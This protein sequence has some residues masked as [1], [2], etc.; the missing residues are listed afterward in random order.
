MHVEKYTLLLWSL[1]VCRQLDQDYDEL[2]ETSGESFQPHAHDEQ[3]ALLRLCLPVPGD[4]F[5]G[6]PVHRLDEE[7]EGRSHL[8]GHLGEPGHG[9]MD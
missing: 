7:L 2:E 1:F 4:L 8:F 9:P 6:V 5:M 3:T